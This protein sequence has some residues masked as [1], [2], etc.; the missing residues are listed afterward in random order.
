MIEKFSQ[1]FLDRC[2]TQAEKNW[3][4]RI[5][6]SQLKSEEYASRFAAKEAVSKALGTGIVGLSFK[7]IELLNEQGGKPVVQLYGNAKIIARELEVNNIQISLA[8]E[9]G[10]ALAFF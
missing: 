2:F 3:C 9:G 8:H 6:D 7:E 10:Q 5:N 1:R 4:N